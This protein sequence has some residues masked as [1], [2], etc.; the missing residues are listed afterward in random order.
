MAS[1]INTRQPHHPPKSSIHTALHSKARR[2]A[3]Q[4]PETV[5]S[6]RESMIRRVNVIKE[7]DS[8]MLRLPS[9]VIKSVLVTTSG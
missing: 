1:A 5:Q 2:Q 7:G 6:I 3:A 9:D 8:V 4:A